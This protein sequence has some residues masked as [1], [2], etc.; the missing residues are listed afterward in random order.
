MA[1]KITY[2]PT[3]QNDLQDIF[4]YIATD[5]STAAEHYL[6]LIK[7]TCERTGAYPFLGRRYDERYSYVVSHQHLIFYSYDRLSDTVTIARIIHTAR[8]ISSLI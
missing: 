5:N 4:D 6:N 2:L 7:A 8:D 1:T 3:A